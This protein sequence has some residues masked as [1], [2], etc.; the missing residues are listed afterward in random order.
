MLWTVAYRLCSSHPTM[1]EKECICILSRRD[2][3]L[4]DAQSHTPS[5]L[6]DIS[7]VCRHQYATANIY[8]KIQIILPFIGFRTAL[9][10]VV[11]AQLH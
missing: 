1:N 7:Y 6:H 4:P 5:N 3:Q 11:G 10:H 8:L 9:P 2:D